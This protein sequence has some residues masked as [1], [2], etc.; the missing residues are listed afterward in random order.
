MPR[1]PKNQPLALIDGREVH[2][3]LKL[4]AGIYAVQ[5]PDPNRAGKYR[6]ASTRERHPLGAW[7]K[8]REII[9]SAYAN[10]EPDR[11]AGP[12]TWEEVVALL[13]DMP[14]LLRPRAVEPYV[15]AI[16]NLRKYVE[17]SG[18]F[19]V[20]PEKAK[21][22]KSA[23]EA[24]PFTKGKPKR[25]KTGE[26]I[27]PKGYTRKPKTVENAIRR[28]SGLWEKLLAHT[29]TP[30]A[31]ANPWVGVKRPVVTEGEPVTADEQEWMH[32]FGWVEAKGWELMSVFLQVKALAGCRTND[33][34]HVKLEQWDRKARVLTINPD[35]DK[36]YQQR[37]IPIPPDLAGRLNAVAGTDYLWDHYAESLQ[38]LDRPMVKDGFRPKRLYWAVRRVF[39]DYEAEHPDRAKLTPHDL[40]GRAITLTVEHTQSIDATAEALHVSAATVRRHY[41]DRQRAFRRQELLKKMANVLLMKPNGGGEYTPG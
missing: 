37:T 19:D 32:F 26:T 22:F 15:G 16:V 33:L 21:R 28:L 17:T 34:C 11:P 14:G 5:F 36:T 2:A 39:E 40:R 23:Y 24:Q 6:E 9:E 13:P 1:P 41:L 25:G 31:R 3:T 20:T 29:P 8:A 27:Q 10:T 30:L 12:V 38:S 18:P 4:R 35:E 7:A